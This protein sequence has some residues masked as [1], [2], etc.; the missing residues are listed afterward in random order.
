MLRNPEAMPPF[1]AVFRMF[2]Q[3]W[4]TMRT[5]AFLAIAASMALAPATAESAPMTR[6]G[7]TVP[8]TRDWSSVPTIPLRPPVAM[9]PSAPAR[10]W[11][12]EGGWRGGQRHWQGHSGR[13]QGNWGQWRGQSRDWGSW[14]GGH[15]KA[16]FHPRRGF[17]MPRVFVSPTFFVPN[18]WSYG[19]AEP[20]YGRRWVRYYDDAV[21]I[22]ERGYIYDTAPGVDWDG[23]EPDYD[24]HGWYDDDEASWGSGVYYARPG[25]GVY[26]AP[27]G[28]TT[29]IVQSAPVVTTTTTTTY[30]DEEVVHARPKRAWKPRPKCACK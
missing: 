17:F 27:P 9:T 4:L 6:H 20:A 30:V 24:H 13:D 21:L 19:L 11:S 25:P 12:S 23:D 18:W 8:T 5:L 3:G 2:R 10:G 22:D 26:Y 7:T 15:G 14:R 29:V 16:N 1:L 28:S